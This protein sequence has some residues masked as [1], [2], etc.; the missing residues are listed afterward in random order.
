MFIFF[1]YFL[2]FWLAWMACTTRKLTGHQGLF[3]SRF[4][5]ITIPLAVL[6]WFWEPGYSIIILILSCLWAGIHIRPGQRWD[7]SYYRRWY[8]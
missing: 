7:G 4:W 2:G 6:V 3:G 8:Y 5:L 1:C